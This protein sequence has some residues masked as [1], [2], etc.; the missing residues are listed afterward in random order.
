M[1]SIALNP[2]TSLERITVLVDANVFYSNDQRNILMTFGVEGVIRL[3]WTDE[4]EAEWV[5]NLVRN[6]PGVLREKIERTCQLMRDAIS[7]Y[8]VVGYAGLTAAT[9]HTDAKDR[10]VA[11]AAIACKPSTLITWNIKDFDKPTLSN[12]GVSVETP[13]HLLCR[14]FDGNPTLVHAA[15]EKA[16]GFVRKNGGKPS[17]PDYL[18][19]LATRGAPS[20]L[21]E[22]AKRLRAFIPE[23]VPEQI[24]TIERDTDLVEV[25]EVVEPPASGPRGGK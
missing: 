17:W 19:I 18:D 10:H 16:Y 4:I 9:G 20:S 13:D 5:K 21:K 3:R 8:D 12:E 11:A 22:F 6:N 15:A 25:E 7:D 2:T 23:D 24:S 1:S 14:V